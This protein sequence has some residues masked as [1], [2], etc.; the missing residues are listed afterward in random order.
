M[1]R[2]KARSRSAGAAFAGA[3]VLGTQ[4]PAAHAAEAVGEQETHATSVSAYTY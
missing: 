4:L 2:S 3:L 1:E